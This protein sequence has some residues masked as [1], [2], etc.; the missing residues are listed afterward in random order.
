MFFR[1]LYTTLNLKHALRWDSR[2]HDS[3]I[4]PISWLST[5][6]KALT[7]SQASVNAH[8]RAASESFCMPPSPAVHVEGSQS[9][10]LK[11]FI[12]RLHLCG[13]LWYR[14]WALSAGV[15]VNLPGLD[16]RA[17]VGQCCGITWWAIGYFRNTLLSFCTEGKR[18]AG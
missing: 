14:Q 6:E 3:S 18:S 8:T 5:K 11:L 7:T 10:L 4:W 12:L 17:K 1:Y 9:C 2:S 15:G 16:Y 13:W